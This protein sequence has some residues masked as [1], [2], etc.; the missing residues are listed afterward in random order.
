L[1]EHPDEARHMGERAA[2]RARRYTWSLA[3]ARLRRMYSD[4]S[5]GALVRCG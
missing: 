1:L 3:A 5:A 2:L 4:L